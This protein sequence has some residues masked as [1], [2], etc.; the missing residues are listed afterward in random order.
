MPI[1][2]EP[3]Q[4]VPEP[5]PVPKPPRGPVKRPRPTRY[6]G[7]YNDRII[8]QAIGHL[9]RV[10]AHPSIALDARAMKRALAEIESLAARLEQF[11]P[12]ARAFKTLAGQWRPA[13]K[14]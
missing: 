5:K 14:R 7:A 3:P 12:K 6:R 1:K 8:A 9:E 11:Q 13:K 4:P 2:P 10:L